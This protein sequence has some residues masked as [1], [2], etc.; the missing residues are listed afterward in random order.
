MVLSV[1]RPVVERNSPNLHSLK[2]DK[3][4]IEKSTSNFQ[5]NDNRNG[6]SL[7]WSLAIIQ[8]AREICPFIEATNI[9]GRLFYKLVR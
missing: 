1:D 6:S 7:V 5:D 4:D 9:C 3:N 2:H 8:L